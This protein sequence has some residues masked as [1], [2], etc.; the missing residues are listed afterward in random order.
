[1]RTPKNPTSPCS[2]LLLLPP[3]SALRRQR[4]SKHV[5]QQQANPWPQ[6][7]VDEGSEGRHAH[8]PVEHGLKL[9]IQRL[10]TKE[11]EV[12]SPLGDD[13]RSRVARCSASA[14]GRVGRRAAR[15]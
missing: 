4:D 12:S 7:E 15:G 3:L 2:I 5:T 1:M 11:P 8:K 14:L 9:P 10:P 13:Y 6:L